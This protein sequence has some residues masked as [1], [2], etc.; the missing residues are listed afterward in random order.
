ML[1]QQTDHFISPQIWAYCYK[2]N[3]GFYIGSQKTLM[4][5][6]TVVIFI[7]IIIHQ[8]KMLPHIL[9]FH[10][11]TDSN[12]LIKTFILP[13]LSISAIHLLAKYDIQKDERKTKPSARGGE[14]AKPYC[15]LELGSWFNYVKASQLFEPKRKS[16]RS[17]KLIHCGE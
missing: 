10:I 15:G 9:S 11:T 17:I 14:S 2:N 7:W 5:M 16:T 6:P 4:G 1:H 3:L 8:L 12:I 13:H